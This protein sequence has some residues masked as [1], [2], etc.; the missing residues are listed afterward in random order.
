MVVTIARVLKPCGTHIARGWQHRELRVLFAMA[1]IEGIVA[2]PGN[3]SSRKFM[4]ASAI[5]QG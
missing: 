3:N 2:R 4:P 5:S 1:A